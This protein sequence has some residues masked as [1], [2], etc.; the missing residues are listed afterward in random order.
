LVADANGNTLGQTFGSDDTVSID[1]PF[2][3]V[4]N[5]TLAVES[6]AVASEADKL[7]KQLANPIAS[8]IS[9]PFQSNED[10]GYGPLGNGYKYT[11]NIQ[12]SSQS[13]LAKIGT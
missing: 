6:Q 13:R 3:T 1:C 8:L 2:R 11:L 9:V 7:A 12:R 10:W 5:L 4:K